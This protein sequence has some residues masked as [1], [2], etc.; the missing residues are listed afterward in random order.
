MLRALNRGEHLAD[1]S[2]YG[3]I[4]GR[5]ANAISANPRGNFMLPGFKLT[6]ELKICGDLPQSSVRGLALDPKSLLVPSNQLCFKPFCSK[7]H[8]VAAAVVYSR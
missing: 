3:L 8:G 5:V 1:P 4:F 2:S 6:A 7:G